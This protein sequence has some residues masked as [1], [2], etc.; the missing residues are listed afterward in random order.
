MNPEWRTRRDGQ[1][2]I[3]GSGD[4]SS[5]MRPGKNGFV[6]VIASLATLREVMDNPEEWANILVDVQWVVAAVLDAKRALPAGTIIQYVHAL[7]YCRL[8][9]NPLRQKTRC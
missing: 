8:L 9:T 6:N 5:L 3:G 1:L 4:W 7:F 2:V